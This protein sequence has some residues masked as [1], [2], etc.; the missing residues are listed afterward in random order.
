MAKPDG[1]P[2]V[3]KNVGTRALTLYVTKPADWSATDTR[4]AIVF[5]H[6]GGWTGGAP[7]QFTEHSKYLATRGMVAIQVEYR[8]LDRQ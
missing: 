6:G 4:P 2:H 5:F 1:D 8:L 7:G 3:Y